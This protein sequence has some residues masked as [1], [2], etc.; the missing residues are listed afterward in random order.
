MKGLKHNGC[1][2]IQT[3]TGYKGHNLS[4]PHYIEIMKKAEYRAL[5]EDLAIEVLQ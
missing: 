3:E 5:L 2:S 4:E 1:L